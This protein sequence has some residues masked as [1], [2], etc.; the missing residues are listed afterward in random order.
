M[1]AVDELAAAGTAMP[2]VSQIV[3]QAG[4]S[5]SSFYTQFSGL[6]D[7]AVAVFSEALQ[8]STLLEAMARGSDDVSDWQATRLATTQLVKHISEHAELY[9][10]GLPATA[11]AYLHVVATVAQQLEAGACLIQAPVNGIGVTAATRY[12]A[13]GMLALLHSWLSGE[14]NATDEQIVDQLMSMLPAWVAGP[15]LP[16]QE[17]P[18]K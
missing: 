9:R 12:L 13:G 1:A 11:G 3:R 8:Q 18:G 14:L 5:R 15:T 10:Q 16:R 7:L 17:S 2:S 4:V 6:E